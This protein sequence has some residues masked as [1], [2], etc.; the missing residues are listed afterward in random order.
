MGAVYPYFVTLTIAKRYGFELYTSHKN[1]LED[2]IP[3][4]VIMADPNKLNVSVGM[5][6]AHRLSYSG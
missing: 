6:C 3:E 2:V 4:A 5:D 1:F